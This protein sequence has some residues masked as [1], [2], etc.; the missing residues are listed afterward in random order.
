MACRTVIRVTWNS[1]RSSSSEGSWSPGADL[2]GEDLPD[3]LVAGQ[4]GPHE[5]AGP[6]PPRRT[7]LAWTRSHSR[8]DVYTT[9]ALVFLLR[10]GRGEDDG[11]GK[12]RD[13]P[14]WPLRAPGSL[15]LCLLRPDARSSDRWPWPAEARDTPRA[16]VGP[17]R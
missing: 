15:R 11:R 1:R 10:R 8:L 7:G 2:L 16:G 13:R 3:L 17:R 9:C 5:E 12:G 4:L 6:P 14:W